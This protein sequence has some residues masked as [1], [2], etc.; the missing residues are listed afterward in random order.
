M[1]DLKPIDVAKK[2]KDITKINVFDDTRKR[3][4]I[5]IRM[6]LCYLLRQKLGMRWVNIA[7]FFSNNGKKMTHA[8]AIHCYKM[9]P[10]YK[11]HNNK[12]AEI[13]RMFSWKSDL[14]YD[15][16]DRIHFLESQIKS[17][18][19]KLDTPLIQLLH[20]IPKNRYDETYERLCTFVKSWEWKS[21]HAKTSAN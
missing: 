17:L 8:T 1:K 5:E 7:K 6:L 18:Q 19:D 16:I 15:E 9:Y 2:L 14:T 12:L 10:V 4:V 11:K 20:K 3:E 21:K 13:E